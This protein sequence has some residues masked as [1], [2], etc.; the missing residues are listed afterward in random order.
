[1]KKA[2]IFAVAMTLSGAVFA[3]GLEN[4]RS[5]LSLMSI[6]T[7]TLNGVDVIM[8]AKAKK[9]N[10]TIVKEKK[11]QLKYFLVNING[12]AVCAD[13]S[14]KL[15]YNKMTANELQSLPQKAE[16]AY[17]SRADLEWANLVGTDF[18]GAYLRGANLRWAYLK[19]ANLRKAYMRGANFS[20]ADLTLADLRGNLNGADLSG[21]N[22]S[23]A[24]L[25]GANLSDAD[26][27]GANL[28][29]ANLE[30]A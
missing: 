12:K 7:K 21:A 22:L 18:S 23:G 15:G 26:F 8:P 14:G 9:I 24:N 28:R 3:N 6:N 4:L 19:N 13:K 2:I 11:K 30:G 1:M 27:N 20:G 29:G 25:S 17:L 16:C 5:Q 10:I